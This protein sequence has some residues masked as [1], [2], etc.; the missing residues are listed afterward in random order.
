[1]DTILNTELV[2]RGCRNKLPQTGW[3]EQ[4]NPSSHTFGGWK[5]E[6]KGS[7]ELVP[8][9]DCEGG[10]SV[11]T[12]LLDLGN[13]RCSL[14]CR[15]CSLSVFTSSFLR[16]CLS[17]FPSFYEDTLGLGLAPVTTSYLDLPA[18]TLFN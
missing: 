9:E 1:M 2:S 15:W 12:S 3:L 17:L 18:K 13:V 10:A 16:T 8:S 4:Q 5:S 11:H 7:A 6:I 14:A